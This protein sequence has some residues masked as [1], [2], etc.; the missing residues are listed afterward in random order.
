MAEE[1]TEFVHGRE[2]VEKVLNTT[3]SLFKTEKEEIMRM[4]REQFEIHFQYAQKFKLSKNDLV[5]IS[6][7][8]VKCGMRNTKAEVKRLM[9]QGGV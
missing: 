5:D 7:L 1:L 9:V 2:A 3:K 8:F 6:S 4:N